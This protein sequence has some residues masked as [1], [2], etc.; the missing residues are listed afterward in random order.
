MFCA[1]MG[2]AIL[3]L[4]AH[5]AFVVNDTFRRNLTI[6]LIIA[7]VGATL[8]YRKSIMRGTEINEP[9]RLFFFPLLVLLKG[10]SWLVR[11]IVGHESWISLVTGAA[12]FAAFIVCYMQVDHFAKKS[13]ARIQG[14]LS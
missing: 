4:M 14:E 11:D 5:I 3:V 9:Q 1:Q 12:V 6:L 8:Y 10:S 7:V 2:V 13:A